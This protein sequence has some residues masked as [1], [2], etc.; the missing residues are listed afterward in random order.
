[1]TKILFKKAIVL[2]SILIFLMSSILPAISSEQIL[3]KSE[4]IEEEADLLDLLIIAPKSFSRTLKP[5]V[6][7]KNSFGVRTKLV[8]LEYIYKT[9]MIG[10]D[11]AEKIKLFIKDALDESG[12]KYVLLVGGIKRP[13]SFKEVYW[14]PVRYIHIEDRWSGFA[15]N[16]NEPKYLSDLYF[17]DIYDSEGNFSSWD[18]DGDGIYGEWNDNRSAD[19][20]LDIKPDVSVGRLPVRNR[21]ELRI[22]V[23]KII[24]YEKCNKTGSEWFNKMMLVAGDTYEGDDYEGESETQ[25]ALDV[26]PGFEP[27]KLWCSEGNLTGPQD[28]ITNLNNGCGFLY[29]AGHGSPFCWGTNDP[30]TEKFV[31][32]LKN[33]HMRKL[34]N[35]YKLPVCVVGGCH[36][37]LFN[38]SFFHTTWHGG[39]PVYECFSWHLTKKYKGGSIATLGNTAL[40]YGAKDKLDP[41][42]GGGG[43]PLTTFFFES[44]GIN[45][46]EYLG[47]M[48]S[49]AI[50]NYA[51]EFTIRWDENSYNDSS[52]DAKTVTQWVLFG[53]PSL[54][55]GGYS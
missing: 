37:S 35:G 13:F 2:A 10:F 27:I 14:L 3:N 43:G 7:H 29:F 46:S 47:D 53:D 31:Y 36:N 1:M 54:K 25:E 19:D 39:F 24:N 26:M 55:I 38:V 50:T 17:A 20:I 4:K 48:W 22:M 51:S 11:K 28:V 15:G 8:T 40:G 21:F 6:C 42:S 30:I 32:G 12:I 44:Y 33:I 5:L 41:S 23:N 52:I 16:Y 49:D 9:N 18:T 45:N 34:K